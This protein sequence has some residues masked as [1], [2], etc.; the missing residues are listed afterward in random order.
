M[1]FTEVRRAL[2]RDFVL[3]FDHEKLPPLS[4]Y[5][6]DYVKS[7]CPVVADDYRLLPLTAPALRFANTSSNCLTDCMFDLQSKYQQFIPDGWGGHFERGSRDIGVIGFNILEGV[8]L[9]IG[10]INQTTSYVEWAQPKLN[11]LFWE[12][13][14]IR[15]VVDFGRYCQAQQIRLPSAHRCP[16]EAAGVADP[17]KSEEFQQE[18]RQRYDGS[19]EALGFAFDQSLD[20]F[21]LALGAN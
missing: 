7:G 9:D 8:V 10:E 1:S 16:A 5:L 18:L 13:L 20:C 19:A 15:A 4:S 2:V 21:V 3:C 17:A 12:R 11:S 6:P 14:L